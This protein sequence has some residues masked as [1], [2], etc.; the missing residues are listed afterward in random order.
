[1]DNITNDP[2][3]KKEWYDKNKDKVALYNKKYYKNKIKKNISDDNDSIVVSTKNIPYSNSSHTKLPNIQKDRKHSRE[4]KH[5]SGGHNNINY[6]ICPCGQNYIIDESKTKINLNGGKRNSRKSH[7]EKEHSKKKH[8]RKEHSRKEHSR[9]EHSRKK[10]TKKTHSKKHSKKTHS[11]RHSKKTHS[12]KTH[13]RK[14]QSRKSHS[15]KH[16]N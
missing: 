11:N 8:S 6:K 9:K 16:H 2:N 13:S 7:N 10:H 4:S 15:R 3:Y 5:M 1:M 12:K 14:S